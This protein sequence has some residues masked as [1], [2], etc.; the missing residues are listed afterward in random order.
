[1]VGAFA[2]SGCAG[3]DDASSEE[4][5]APEDAA[6]WTQLFNGVD[7]S[8]WTPKIRGEAPGEDARGTFS[9]RDGLLTVDYGE[10]D[11]EAG[12]ENTF[13]HLFYDTPF[14]A[15]ELRVEYRFVGEQFAGG[16]GWA[17]ANSGVMFHAQSVASM[18]VDQDFPVSLEVQFLGGRPGETRPTANLCTPGTHV[19]VD[20]SLETGHCIQAAAPTYPDTAWV[21]VTLV[22][23]VDGSVQHLIGDDVVLEYDAPVV[24]GGEANGARADVLE[25]RPLRSGFIALQSESHPIQFRSVRIRPLGE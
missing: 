11:A 14:D 18:E 24:G 22:V 15:Y 10:Y 16:P 20:G 7:L 21:E 3:P 6:G 25:P 5:A 2:T 13:G 17:R 8:G 19:S 12:F 9:V 1:M 4:V 23:H